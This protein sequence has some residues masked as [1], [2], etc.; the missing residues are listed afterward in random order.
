MNLGGLS[1]YGDILGVIE[2]VFGASICEMEV[3][4]LSLTH[5]PVPR[6]STAHLDQV[7]QTIQNL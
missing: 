3:A 6:H 4:K 5:T 1:G 2:I 7:Q